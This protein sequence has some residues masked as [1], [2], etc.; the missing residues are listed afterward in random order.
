VNNVFIKFP[1]RFA[2]NEGYDLVKS[3][4]LTGSW[5]IKCT[6]QT[7]MLTQKSLMS[8]YRLIDTLFLSTPLK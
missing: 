6:G 8:K 3:L 5:K 2:G 7:G 1:V 4:L